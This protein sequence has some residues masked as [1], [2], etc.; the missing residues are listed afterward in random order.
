MS[1]TTE[2]T[3]TILGR[4]DHGQL[5]VDANEKLEELAKACLEFEGKGKLVLTL[6][7]A[8]VKGKQALEVSVA[9]KADIPGP[10]RPSE[11]YFASDEGEVS[12][13]DPRQPALPGTDKVTPIR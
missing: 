13:K 7:V 11:L 3:L 4:A 2:N 9:M 5:I 1:G 8:K 12:R 6:S 10:A